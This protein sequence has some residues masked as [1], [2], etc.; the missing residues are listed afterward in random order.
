MKSEIDYTCGGGIAD[1]TDRSAQEDEHRAALKVA[2][3]WK[4]PPSQRRLSVEGA[5]T[6]ACPGAQ[7]M[8]SGAL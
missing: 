5:C 1:G 6:C 3:L 2:A 7:I 8:E 4:V